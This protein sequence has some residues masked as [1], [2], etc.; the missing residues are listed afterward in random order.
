MVSSTLI[1]QKRKALMKWQMTHTIA[2]CEIEKEIH[3]QIPGEDEWELQEIRSLEERPF[4]YLE[5]QRR[6][7]KMQREIHLIRTKAEISKK[8]WL[9]TNIEPYWDD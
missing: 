9:F 6:R 7:K 8:C 1:E 2:R 5:E 4:N 3:L